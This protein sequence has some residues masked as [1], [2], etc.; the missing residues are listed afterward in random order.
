MDFE[1]SQEQA[2]LRDVSRSMLAAHCTP[3]Q[4][5]ALTAA[6]ADIDDKLWQR[7][8]EIGWTGLAVPERFGGA[9][10]GLVE[11]ALVAEELGRAVA[12]GPWFDTALSAQLAAR[13][14]APDDLVRGLAAGE[15]RAAVAADPELVLSA[16]SV[17]WLLTV[18]ATG[19][20]GFVEAPHAQP[21]LRRTID[22]TRVFFA[23]GALPR[24]AHVLDVDPQWV[25]D[26]AVIGVAADALGVGQRLLE[27]TVHYAKMRHQ[28]GRP[29]GSFQVTKHK[30][31]DMLIALKGLR[32]A[33]YYA[34]LSLEAN[35]TDATTA[36]SVA[37]AF[38]AEY[39][40]A[41]AGHAL[42][43]HGGIG[44]TWE[45]NLHL[46]LRRAKTDEVLGGDAHH[47]HDRIARTL[48][49]A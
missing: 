33:T 36:A 49:N 25:R 4:V 29:I 8:V 47:H 17:N 31:A 28:F 2:L 7:G 48:A 27:M 12:P 6:D 10:M 44:F 43:I 45:H 1:L 14:G 5:R 20:V 3:E 26:A 18:D 32:A 19:V 23:V 42:Q 15:Q 13:G 35:T 46:Y 38:A 41:I 37:K 40:P 34:A 24:P 30:L 39:V 22:Q 21:R 16:E 11:L 9:G